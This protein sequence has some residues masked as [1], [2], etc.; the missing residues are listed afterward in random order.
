M[1]RMLVAI[2]PCR[3]SS[4]TGMASAPNTAT[5]SFPGSASCP[6]VATEAPSTPS[7][8]TG[9]NCPSTLAAYSFRLGIER[10]TKRE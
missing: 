6:M 5:I 8:T 1:F 10:G 4:S 9:M 3:T 7:Q 2:G